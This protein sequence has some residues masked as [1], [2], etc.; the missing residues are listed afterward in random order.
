MLYLASIGMDI[1]III[2]VVCLAFIVYW[3][4]EDTFINE[5]EDDEDDDSSD[6]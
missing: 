2:G 4:M 6:S 3:F 1:G 5:P